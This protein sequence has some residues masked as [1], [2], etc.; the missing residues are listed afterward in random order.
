MTPA[1]NY[2]YNWVM[3]KKLNCLIPVNA[4]KLVYILHKPPKRFKCLTDRLR[5]R[6]S[7][8]RSLPCA[9]A[10]ECRGLRDHRRGVHV[11]TKVMS[12]KIPARCQRRCFSPSYIFHFFIS[13]FTTREQFVKWLIDNIVSCNS[14]RFLKSYRCVLII[15]MGRLPRMCSAYYVSKVNEITKKGGNRENKSGCIK[16]GA[17]ASSMRFFLFKA[18]N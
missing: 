8:A 16:T 11:S 6:R 9:T 1:D 3:S 7:C 15:R 4:E 14:R 12:W 10:P 13:F 2:A 18:S 17:L 5:Y